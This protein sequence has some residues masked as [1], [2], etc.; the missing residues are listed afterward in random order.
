MWSWTTTA[1]GQTYLLVW[2]LVP[3]GSRW[4]I[5]DVATMRNMERSEETEE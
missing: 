3:N 2:T 5:I 1:P 4:A